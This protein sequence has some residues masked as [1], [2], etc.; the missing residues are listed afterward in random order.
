MTQLLLSSVHEVRRAARP[1]LDRTRQE[2]APALSEAVRELDGR[3]PML[4]RIIGYHLGL[5]DA[6][7]HPE[8]GDDGGIAGTMCL[9]A[10]AA[11]AVGTDSALSTACAVAMEL[12]KDYTQL[13]D[14]I[15]DDDPVRRGRASAWQVFGVGPT[16]LAADATRALAMDLLAAQQ[17]HGTAA[18]WH[19]QAALDRCTI[20]Q[21]QDF[22]TSARPW[23]GPK[24]VSLEEYRVIAGNKTSAILSCVLSLGAVAN[25]C[26]A[27]TVNRLRQA[28]RHLGM[29]WQ[30]LDDI[31]DL[32][33]EQTEGDL[34]Q[35]CNDLAQGKKT[36]PV[37]VALAA[38]AH[39]E[40]L[41]AL[42]AA[43]PR[44]A[45]QVRAAADLI[46]A[47]GGRAAAEAEVRDHFQAAMT[48]LAGTSLEESTRADLI[49]LACMIGIRGSNQTL[50]IAFPTPTRSPEVAP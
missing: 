50:T 39:A 12:A 5:N 32:W 13:Q 2:L 11:R 42:L 48:V 23:R 43:R 41:G 25:G 7:G 38:A 37:I 28:G 49:T 10:L 40:P 34:P 4:G 21:A 22:A 16:I 20:G 46:A 45:D 26:D 1:I 18:M 17:P 35:G 33:C 24:A 27:D 6:D 36:F 15:I 3:E 8:A 9:T 29:A 47:A 19:L 14:D 31:L 44:T 30:P